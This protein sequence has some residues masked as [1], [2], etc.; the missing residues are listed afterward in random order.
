MKKLLFLIMLVLPACASKQIVSDVPVVAPQKTEVELEPELEVESIPHN[1][2]NPVDNWDYP[3]KFYPVSGE[4]LANFF[5]SGTEVTNCQLQTLNDIAVANIQSFM[6]T[7]KIIVEE[8]R[9]FI[10]FAMKPGVAWLLV[11]NQNPQVA[12]HECLKLQ[13]HLINTFN[14]TLKK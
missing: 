2:I 13:K 12:L 7:Q 3:G 14:F 4:H 5:N 9:N 10:Q 8:K 1:V 11:K 6:D